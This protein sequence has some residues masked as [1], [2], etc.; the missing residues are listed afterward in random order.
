MAYESQTVSA[1]DWSAAVPINCGAQGHVQLRRACNHVS[2][3]EGIPAT[4]ASESPP[5]VHGC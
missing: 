2:G 4:V 3:V 5:A 1:I